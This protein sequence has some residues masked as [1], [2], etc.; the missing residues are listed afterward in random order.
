MALRAYGQHNRWNMKQPANDNTQASVDYLGRT[1]VNMRGPRVN[2]LQSG[3]YHVAIWSN[4]GEP[5]HTLICSSNER[6]R[7]HLL[8]LQRMRALVPA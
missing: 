7:Q 5:S 1:L 3:M 4:D 2:I 8:K 6:A